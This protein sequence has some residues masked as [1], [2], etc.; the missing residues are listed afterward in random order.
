MGITKVRITGG[1]P[2]VRRGVVDFISRLGSISGLKDVSLTTN[3]VLLESFAAELYAAGIKRINVSVDSLNS[4]KYA[5]ITRG[6]KL[7]DVLS[8]IR[9]ADRN[10]ASRRLN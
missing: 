8:G 9:E 3:G 5:E 1:E 2:L 10:R 7:R 4:E 6:G